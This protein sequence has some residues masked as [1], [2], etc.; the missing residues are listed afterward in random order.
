MAA[1]YALRRV[2]A[3]GNAKV[4]VVGN[5]VFPEV[6]VTTDLESIITGILKQNGVI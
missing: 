1:R 6:T 3:Q 4:P 5:G 2:M